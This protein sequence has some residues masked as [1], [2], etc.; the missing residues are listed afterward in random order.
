MVWN[1]IS[2]FWVLVFICAISMGN[3]YA[4]GGSFSCSFGQQGACLDYGDKVCSSFAK[5]VK[6]D[7]VCFDSYTCDYNGFV[8]KSKFN[9]LADDFDDLLKKCRNIASEYDAVV[10]DY[11]EL[12]RKHKMLASEYEEIQS[13]IS[14][15]TSLDEAKRCY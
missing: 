5:C 7:A 4:Y 6:S 9:E 12:I 14:Y 2:C 13:C 3:T 1:C 11:N 8:C 15:A 10:N